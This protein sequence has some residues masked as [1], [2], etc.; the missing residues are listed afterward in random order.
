MLTEAAQCTPPAVNNKIEL[1]GG[2]MA[3][4]TAGAVAPFGSRTLEISN[5]LIANSQVGIPTLVPVVCGSKHD[6]EIGGVQ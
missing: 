1:E 2:R 4:A 6:D 3:V 5:S